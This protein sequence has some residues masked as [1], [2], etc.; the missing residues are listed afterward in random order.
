MPIDPTLPTSYP[1][2]RLLRDN[3]L[4]AVVNALDANRDKTLQRNE[5]NIGEPRLQDRLDSNRD[6]R[7][8]ADEVKGGFQ[9]DEFA[10]SFGG[11]RAS[12]VDVMLKLDNNQDGYLAAN[13]LEMN[14]KMLNQLD[15]YGSRKYGAE[16]GRTVVDQKNRVRQTGEA[17][18]D[19]RI[20]ISEIANALTDGLLKIGSRFTIPNR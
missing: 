12:A 8:S 16:N 6:G 7:F 11:A 2:T 5:L 4:N 9:R 10:I 17:A 14:D 1:A 3:E 13:E 19:G 20:S 18:R 15:G